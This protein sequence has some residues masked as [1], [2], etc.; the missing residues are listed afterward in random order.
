ME[1]QP[2]LECQ[3]TIATEPETQRDKRGI[4]KK[5][6]KT[7]KFIAKYYR[8]LFW[9]AL[10]KYGFISP[11][12]SLKNQKIDKIAP[13]N[14]F[15]ACESCGSN[16]VKEILVT[17]DECRIVECINCGLKFTSPRIKEK[18]WVDYLKKETL[19][20]I[21]VTENRLK[22]GVALSS[23]IK[24]TFPN[25]YENR[26]KMENQII[27]ETQQYL[28]TKINRLHDV[29]C[30]VGFLLNVANAK[31][32]KATGNDLNGYACKV[33]KERFNLEVYNNVLSK[34]Q[35]EDGILD[36]VVMRDYI[37]HTYHPIEDFKSAYKFLRVGGIIWIETFNVD[38]YKFD[39]YKGDW[40]M[41]FWN[42]VYHF[43]PK[44]LKDM[45]KKAGFDIKSISSNYYQVPLKIIAKKVD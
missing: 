37:E 23:N 18:I 10:R 12:N 31:G 8:A 34:C 45:V 1:T 16:F 36:A 17:R 30:G 27:N 6:D 22:Y 14:E 44:T 32:I 41:L 20:S 9:K 21:E 40:N 5:H 42:H 7:L 39:Q 11:Y 13:F 26:I 3:D 19:R 2:S 15:P 35:I 25:W 24:L 43:S 28:D 29:G 33:M 38:C 4:A